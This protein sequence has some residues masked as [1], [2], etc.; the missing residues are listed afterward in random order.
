MSKSTSFVFEAPKLVKI[1]FK[2]ENIC[3]LKVRVLLAQ[4]RNLLITL[5]T[6][7]GLFYFSGFS[8]QVPDH[9][10][11]VRAPHQR[12]KNGAKVQVDG[13]SVEHE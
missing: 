5:T 10:G 7:S 11:F 8:G 12:M 1:L 9:S 13:D 2:K 6:E 4:I 3:F